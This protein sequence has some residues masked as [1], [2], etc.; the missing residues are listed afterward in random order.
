MMDDLKHKR[1]QQKADIDNFLKQNGLL[2]FRRM[3]GYETERMGIVI[4]HLADATQRRLT[5]QTVWD[6]VRREQ[7]KPVEQIISLPEISG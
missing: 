2:T 5:A 1:D 7:G 3:D 6:R 4:N